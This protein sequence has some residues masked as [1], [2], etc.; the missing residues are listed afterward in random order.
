MESYLLCSVKG[1][2]AQAHVWA[3]GPFV[4]WEGWRRHRGKRSRWSALSPVPAI[5]MSFHSL[6]PTVLVCP[7]PLGKG[8]SQELKHTAVDVIC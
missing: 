8:G 4:P 5:A 6:T 1:R 7:G 2:S 3:R